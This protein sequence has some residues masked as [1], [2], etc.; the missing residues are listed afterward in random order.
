MLRLT[1]VCSAAQP[2][3]R[4]QHPLAVHSKPPPT[5]AQ[6]ED[7]FDRY[8]RIRAVDIKNSSRGAY[9]FVEFE[10]GRDASDAVRKEDGMS[11]LGGRLRVSQT[12]AAADAAA[13]ARGGVGVGVGGGRGA[14]W[15]AVV[16][17]VWW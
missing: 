17:W 4:A 13:A 2:R 10:D 9:A 8:G 7:I 14:C 6:I 3:A 15:V 1:P 5:A 11:Q 12:A 16:G